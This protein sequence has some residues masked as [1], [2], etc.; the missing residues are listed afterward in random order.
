MRISY[1]RLWH[2]LL[3]R[4]MKKK[5]L[6][7]KAGISQPTIAKMARGGSINTDILVKICKTL[8]CTF[9]DI[10]EIVEDDENV[11][12]NLVEKP[13]DFAYGF[14]PLLLG[15]RYGIEKYDIGEPTFYHDIQKLYLP[16]NLR[17][18]HL[19]NFLKNYYYDEARFVFGGM[20]EQYKDRLKQNNIKLTVADTAYSIV[21]VDDRKYIRLSFALMMASERLVERII[22]LAIEKALEPDVPWI[23]HIK[24]L[25]DATLEKEYKKFEIMLNADKWNN[26]KPPQQVGLMDVKFS[27]K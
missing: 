13:V 27:S 6:A 17:N 3:D 22:M 16:K 2:I 21:S 26:G 9:D 25:E 14:R 1:I 5:E 23:L 12:T 15:K 4:G 11:V 19:R 7:E 8:D 24:D 20:A 18:Y 10:M